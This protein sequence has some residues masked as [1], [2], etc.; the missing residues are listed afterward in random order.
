MSN[1]TS[2]RVNS[3]ML[4]RFIG[5]KVRLPCKILTINKT[6]NR[7]TVQAS[8]GGDVEIQAF[9]EDPGVAYIE[10]IGMVVDE[11]TIKSVGVIKF[12]DNLDMSTVEETIKIIHDPRFVS[13]FFP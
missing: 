6:A 5:K 7:A 11:T 9:V 13:V 2:P 12:G 8:D 3:S 1:E 4:P 10:V